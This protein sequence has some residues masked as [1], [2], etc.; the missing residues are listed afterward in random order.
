M[1]RLCIAVFILTVLDVLCTGYG[2]ANGYIL[3]LNPII[4]F[5]F[6]YSIPLTCVFSILSIG[7]AILWVYR[8]KIRW[9]FYPFLA[10]TVLKTAVIFMHIHW[11]AVVMGA[12]T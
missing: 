11:I 9:T 6:K 8:Q 1:K 4:A 2:V 3:E 5:L 7:A 10:L 12:S